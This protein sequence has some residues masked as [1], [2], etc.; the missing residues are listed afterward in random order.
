MGAGG[1][2]GDAQVLWPVHRLPTRGVLPLRV[3]P[4]PAAAQTGNVALLVGAHDLL[5]GK[6]KLPSII[7]ACV[8]PQHRRYGGHGPANRCRRRG[9]WQAMQRG[10]TLEVSTSPLPVQSTTSKICMKGGQG[11]PS[12]PALP[13]QLDRPQ[14][15][16]Q[17]RQLMYAADSDVEL[18]S[19][20]I[21]RQCRWQ[22]RLILALGLPSGVVCSPAAPG[23]TPVSKMA[24]T[25][26]RPS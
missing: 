24:T 4:Q 2:N 17:L 20:I 19:C 10:R 11:R 18:P 21:R 26:P 6:K 25:V 12:A 22:G 3:Q 8:W 5:V 7:A 15:P 14:Q 23:S 13:S 9:V 16:Q 1:S